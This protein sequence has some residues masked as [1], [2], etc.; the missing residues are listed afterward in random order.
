MS[1]E[2]YRE[3]ELGHFGLA[4]DNY[5]HFT[6]PIRRYPDLAV[7]RIMS[8]YLETKDSGLTRARFNKFVYAASSRSSEA[9]ITALSVERSCDDCYKAEYLSTMTGEQAD[10]VICSVMDFGF[11]V[12]LDNTCEGLVRTKS[13]G[14]E[15]YYVDNLLTLKSKTSGDSYSVG[16]RVT[17]K[18]ESCNI[19]E[20]NVDFSFVKKIE[21]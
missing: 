9:E 5:A 11:F 10:G 14:G 7:H 17:V 2:R 8:D 19:S 20:G 18:I 15:E 6:S 21:D 1:K 3:E 12:T 16:E 13:L 4:L